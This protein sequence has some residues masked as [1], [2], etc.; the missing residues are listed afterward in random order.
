[1]SKRPKVIA[2]DYH[3][4]GVGG[5]GFMVS[6][7][8]DPEHGRMLMVD[9]SHGYLPP[10]ER[11]EDYEDVEYGYTAVLKLD[12]AAKGNIFMHPEPGVPGSGGNAW[13]GDRVGDEYRPLVQR[14]HDER[15]EALLARIRA[16]RK[17]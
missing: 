14:V 15:Y 3:R 9:F 10:A 16:E 13:R 6:I 4:N 17:A 7:V 12:E 5:A 2:T 1:M 8:E 11:D